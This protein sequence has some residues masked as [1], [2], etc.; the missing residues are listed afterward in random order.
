MVTFLISGLA[1]N[2]ILKMYAI[3]RN[4][5]SMPFLKPKRSPSPPTIS[6]TTA[7]PTMAV[8]RIPEKLPWCSSTELSARENIMGYMTE[9]KKP[10]S[11]NAINATALDAHVSQF[12]EWL[13]W[14]SG[15]LAEVPKGAAERKKWLKEKWGGRSS[16]SPEVR[17]SLEK[18][19]GAQKAQDVKYA[20]AFEI[21]EYGKQPS[22]E[23]IRRL[24][25]M[26]GQ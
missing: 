22:D 21:C 14:T 9:E 23:E 10:T 17:K 15:A 1:Q 26:L 13:P 6:G 12:Y 25:P 11:G 24:F 8:T 7:P 5:N 4:K 16:I 3:V 19:Y 18:W 20:E 2:P